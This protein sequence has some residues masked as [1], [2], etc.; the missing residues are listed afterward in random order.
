[1]TEELFE[2]MVDDLGDVAEITKPDLRTLVDAQAAIVEFIA[3][4]APLDETLVAIAGEIETAWTQSDAGFLMT[5]EETDHNATTALDLPDL[6]STALRDVPSTVLIDTVNRGDPF[7]PFMLSGNEPDKDWAELAPALAA[8]GAG[9][10]WFSLVTP[11]DD[12]TPSWLIVV[13]ADTK[14]L[15]DSEDALLRRFAHLARLAIDQ[16]RAELQLQRLI[17]DERRRLAGVIHDDPIQALTAV[18]LRIQR[19]ARHVEGDIAEQVAGLHHAVGNAIER[20]RR[21]L[22][23]LHPPTL[24]DDGLV[25]A[26]DVYLGEV[27]EPL[28][29]ECSLTDTVD[30][31][32]AFGTASLAYRLAAE[33]L[34]NVAKHAD[35]SKVSVDVIIE[36]GAVEITI[37][38]NGIGFDTGTV[39]RRRA[40]HMG[41]SACRELATRASGTW[42]VESQ[43]GK[44]TAVRIALPG[45]APIDIGDAT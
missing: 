35:A 8:S 42:N 36:L 31:E 38:D 13:V 22:I 30:E 24:D 21:L 19:L 32:P 7:A 28:G 41:I 14:P 29:L 3:S 33:A 40:G 37:I 12:E 34:W 25:S 43:H 17:A 44:G 6:L 2:S 16:H 9:A 1:M 4:R 10:A 39:Q 23:D 45:P 15:T 20:M 26:I 11:P 5:N 27:I 18:G